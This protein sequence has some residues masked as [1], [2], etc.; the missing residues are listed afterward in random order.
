MKYARNKHANLGQV[1]DTIITNK[2]NAKFYYVHVSFI[3]NILNI[4]NIQYQ[5]NYKYINMI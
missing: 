1:E 5:Y 4:F 2:V 3:L